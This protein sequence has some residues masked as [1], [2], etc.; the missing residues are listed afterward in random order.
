MNGLQNPH[1]R[2]FKE[3]FTQPNATRDFA[4]R[5]LPPEVVQL[6]DLTM[7]ELQK[8]SFIDGD[9]KQHFSDL[10]Y[11]VRLRH[12]P[13]A[14]LYLLFEHKSYPDRL[15]PLQMLRYMV[16]IWE[17]E[18]QSPEALLL[19]VIVPVLLYHGAEPGVSSWILAAYSPHLRRSQATCLTFAAS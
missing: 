10:L 13:A 3:T 17:R 5:Y 11:R 2:F 6:L 9:L 7:L 19:P 1:D 12:G 15:T 18:V 4:A 14:F 8:E 16:H